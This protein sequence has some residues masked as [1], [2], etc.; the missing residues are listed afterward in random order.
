MENDFLEWYVSGGTSTYSGSKTLPYFASGGL[1]T[2]DG[3]SSYLV[4]ALGDGRVHANKGPAATFELSGEAPPPT[5]IT[6]ATQF[7][8][9]GTPFSMDLHALDAVVYSL[10]SGALPPG[11]ALSKSGRLAG[12]ATHTGTYAFSVR[13]HGVIIGLDA[14]RTFS[15]QIIATPVWSTPEDLPDTVTGEPFSLQL[16]APTTAAATTYA[17]HGGEL[18]AGLSLS[19]AGLLSGTPTAD[20]LLSWTIRATGSNA[21]AD[22]TFTALF[23]PRPTWTT[24]AALGSIEVGDV[25]SIALSAATAAPIS[26]QMGGSTRT[27]RSAAAPLFKMDAR[28]ITS[29]TNLNALEP[30]Q[31]FQ[32]N[33][34]YPDCMTTINGRAAVDLYGGYFRG[35]NSVPVSRDM[36]LFAVLQCGDLDGWDAGSGGEGNESLNIVSLGWRGGVQISKPANSLAL[37]PDGAYGSVSRRFSFTTLQ[38]NN[39]EASQRRSFDSNTGVT[40]AGAI[41]VGVPMIY[42]MTFSATSPTVES[43]VEGAGGEN[44]TFGE[45]DHATFKTYVY[46]ALSGLRTTSNTTDDSADGVQSVVLGNLPVLAGKIQGDT[47]ERET[48]T[49]LGS[50]EIYDGAMSEAQVAAKMGELR[51]SWGV[52]PSFSLVSGT[53]P[54]GVTLTS[55]GLLSG[56]PASGTYSFLITSGSGGYDRIF[57]VTIVN[58]GLTTL[59]S[60]EIPPGMTLGSDGVLTGAPT[61]AGAYSFTVR[62]TS[63]VSDLVYSDRTFTLDVVYNVSF[64]FDARALSSLATPD[65]RNPSQTFD[66]NLV[67]ANTVSTI[68]G[69]SAI[70]FSGG[71][72]TSS[73]ESYPVSDEMT[74]VMVFEPSSSVGNFGSFFTYHTSTTIHSW[75][76]RQYFGSPVHAVRLDTTLGIGS[77]A[78][79]AGNNAYSGIDYEPNQPTI[80]VQR[81]SSIPGTGTVTGWRQ[82]IVRMAMYTSSSGMRTV[83]NNTVYVLRFDGSW[84]LS[85]GGSRTHSSNNELCNSK[86]GLVEVYNI[87]L[88]DAQVDA[89]VAELKASWGIL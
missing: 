9:A 27:T 55:G 87:A 46:D 40:N 84:K 47:G 12:V 37:A 32:T 14:F 18:P 48:D 43:T 36:T 28:Q 59:V 51:E 60:G 4:Y 71:W 69:R 10:V 88:S 38:T 29:I 34:A 35:P 81:T 2:A 73:T 41:N 68:N 53:L 77:W 79:W 17:L 21:Y 6:S 86:I 67:Y 66:T 74:L 62:A 76:V 89:K 11:L 19:S 61:Q 31:V 45:A 44:F 64:L 22:R 42:A 39:Y 33:L 80:L 54:A 25:T 78:A 49:R 82:G 16:Y 52:G 1:L 57:T 13:A 23:V 24:D 5:W 72:I 8:P 50:L 7:A 70:N 26:I 56:T 58:V 3:A 63:P 20:G 85:L 83:T 30:V 75:D 65:S 15:M